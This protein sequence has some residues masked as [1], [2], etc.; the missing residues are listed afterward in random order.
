ME[1]NMPQTVL[2]KRSIENLR[3][4]PNYNVFERKNFITDIGIAFYDQLSKNWFI[5][6]K[7]VYP[8]Y[9]YE[10]LPL[11]KLIEDSMPSQEEIDKFLYEH[12]T[13]GFLDSDTGCISSAKEE[14]IEWLKNKLKESNA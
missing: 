13:I 4:N 14:G 11:S 5:G 12:T 7:V 9:W 10:E 6:K 3:D 2:V 8:Q 1:N